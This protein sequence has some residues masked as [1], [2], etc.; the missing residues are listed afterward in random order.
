MIH[1]APGLMLAEV[2]Q[3][4]GEGRSERGGVGREN[5]HHIIIWSMQH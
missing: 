2:L 4:G 1:A 3:M 5:N